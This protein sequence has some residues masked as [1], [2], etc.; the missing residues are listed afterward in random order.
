MITVLNAASTI[1]QLYQGSQLYWWRTREYPEKTIDLLHV[2]DKTL[3]HNVVSS[4]RR[5]EWDLNLQLM[6]IAQVVSN[7]TIIRT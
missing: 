5:D 6:L 7:P 3:S 4:A 1:F 2:T